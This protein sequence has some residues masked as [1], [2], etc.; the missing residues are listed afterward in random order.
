MQR[1]QTLCSAVLTQTNTC[2]G[3]PSCTGSSMGEGQREKREKMSNDEDRVE[4]GGR[5]GL[6][7]QEREVG[8]S[9]TNRIP[10]INHL[11]WT[12]GPLKTG[13]NRIPSWKCGLQTWIWQKNISCQT[14]QARG[15]KEGPCFL[16]VRETKTGGT[17]LTRLPEDRGCSEQHMGLK[18]EARGQPPRPAP[19][20]TGRRPVQSSGN[21]VQS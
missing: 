20:P 14:L 12:A 13:R 2:R 4:D 17:C 7:W 16:V 15:A 19:H 3:W 5:E 18:K 8:D 1:P 6:G 21:R 11:V 10:L 9:F